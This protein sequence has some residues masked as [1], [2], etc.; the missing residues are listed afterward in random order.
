MF[1]LH[2]PPATRGCWL[3]PGYG[4]HAAPLPG[5]NLLEPAVHRYILQESERRPAQCHCGPVLQ[6]FDL[7][8]RVLRYRATERDSWPEDRKE[9]RW[10]ARVCRQA[11]S[12]DLHPEGGHLD[13]HRI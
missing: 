7:A 4:R 11:T 12:H 6:G 3:R 5:A 13:V 9:H 8:A 10:L 2:V 1:H